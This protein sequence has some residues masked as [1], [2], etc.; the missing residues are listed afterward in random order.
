MPTIEISKK[1]LIK[2]I[3]KKVKNLDDD[4]LYVKGEI[5]ESKGDIIKV[6]S[7]DTNRPDLWSAEGIAREIKSKYKIK[8]PQYKFKKGKI[9]VHVDESVKKIRPYTACAVIRN[10]K[11]TKDI[12]SQLIQ[13]QEKIAGT[14][15]RNRKEVSI[16]VYDLK[17]I[18]PPIKYCTIDPEKI[19]FIPLDHRKKMNVKNIFEN[20]QKGKE[21]GHLLKGFKKY[22]IFK[23]S[24]DEIMSLV[25][26][27]NSND[28]G[29]IGLKSKDLF[30]EM[31][32]K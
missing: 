3:G 29:N 15:G 2:L 8:F 18:K 4:L 12:M 19:K 13:L 23:D 32:R 7:K 6:D 26:I 30:I 31:F 17:K 9:K 27:I 21:Y 20:V 14:F 11:M 22:T 24:K 1:D 28:S 5:D 16:G 10:L 25:P